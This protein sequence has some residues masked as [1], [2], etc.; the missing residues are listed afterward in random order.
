MFDLRVATL[1]DGTSLSLDCP[2][3]SLGVTIVFTAQLVFFSIR[4]VL[5]LIALSMHIR[6]KR[7]VTFN[8]IRT[9][10]PYRVLMFDGLIAN[11]I[12][13]GFPIQ[14]LLPNGFVA[15]TDVG[16]TL[17][18]VLGTFLITWAYNDFEYTQF[19]AIVRASSMNFELHNRLLVR[20]RKLMW[21][22]K[23]SYSC[24]AIVP[25]LV[26]LGLDKRL[27]PV[28]N[29]EF[30]AL[31]LR[32]IGIVIWVA[33]QWVADLYMQREIR[34][35]IASLQYMNLGTQGASPVLHYLNKHAKTSNRTAVIAC[36]I[37]IF[38]SLPYFWPFQ[39]Y[40]MTIVSCLGILGSAN[41]AVV[42]MTSA[43]LRRNRDAQSMIESLTPSKN[44][45]TAKK[46]GDNYP[47]K[48]SSITTPQL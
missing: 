8:F 24:F 4:Q 21:M 15:G 14:K 39:G 7:K 16:V 47:P 20:Q 46:F 18:L 28:K 6:H 48:K 23:L 32:N 25:T 43:Q 29:Y 38:F 5:L 33:S 35:I 37:W 19:H 41:E 40:A 10:M 45:D 12:T 36:L 9:Y 11:P 44:R 34:T 26:A 27:G 1:P 22:T 2:N 17:C 3:P 30:V 13:L 31:I 42:L